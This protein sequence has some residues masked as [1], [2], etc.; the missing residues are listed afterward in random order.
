MLTA[1]AVKT[2]EELAVIIARLGFCPINDWF[3]DYAKFGG[4]VAES[5][6]Q[7]SIMAASA[8]PEYVGSFPQ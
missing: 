5:E 2:N 4:E 6:L 1:G 3:N 8:G 7:E